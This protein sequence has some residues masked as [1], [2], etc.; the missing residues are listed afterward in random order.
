MKE[1][2]ADYAWL[3]KTQRS[4]HLWLGN[5]FCVSMQIIPL[6]EVSREHLIK[7]AKKSQA[8]E[9]KRFTKLFKDVE[10]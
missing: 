7:F 5:P 10:W 4:W 6:K 1:N 8:K 2:V 3:S 9:K